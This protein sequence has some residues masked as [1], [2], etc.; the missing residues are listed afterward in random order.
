MIEAGAAM[1]VVFRM[2]L[3]LFLLPSAIGKLMNW[4]R[5]AQGI[6]DF[7]ILPPTAAKLFAVALPWAE[8]ALAFGL[9]VGTALPIAGLATAMLLVSFLCA[10][11]INLR[12]GRE[13]SCNCFGI[14]GTATLGWGAVARNAILIALALGVTALSFGG[15]FTQPY[16]G[17]IALI[18]PAS[19]NSLIPIALLV[20]SIAVLVQ[21]SEWGLDLHIQTTQMARSAAFQLRDSGRGAAEPLPSGLATR[22]GDNVGDRVGRWAT[23]SSVDGTG[24]G[25]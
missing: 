12:R 16:V 19:L 8:L 15:G 25:S 13:I 5:F 23:T 22:N 4:P 1:L 17:V 3:A 14:A 24:Y 11:V 21:L 6:L 18:W 2:D 7:K 9:I 10:V 20:A